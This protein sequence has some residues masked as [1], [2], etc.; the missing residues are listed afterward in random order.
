[1][2]IVKLLCKQVAENDGYLSHVKHL[3]HILAL[4]ILIAVTTP[5]GDYIETTFDTEFQVL[6]QGGIDQDHQENHDL[7]STFCTCH[8]CQNSINAGILYTLGSQSFT[9]L[10]QEQTNFFSA[11]VSFSIWEPPPPPPPFNELISNI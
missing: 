3:S 6:L 9:K 10:T 2:Q 8:C 11:R 4:S 1:M 7:C 5:C